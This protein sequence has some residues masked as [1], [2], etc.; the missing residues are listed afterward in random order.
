MTI[1]IIKRAVFLRLSVCPSHTSV[2][3]LG[4]NQSENVNKNKINKHGSG[5]YT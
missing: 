1:N 5:V 2:I 3:S 4:I